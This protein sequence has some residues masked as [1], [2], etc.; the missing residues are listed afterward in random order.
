MTPTRC[1]S[2]GCGRFV[3]AGADRC[4][5]HPPPPA[6]EPD[7]VLRPEI[8]ALRLVLDRLVREMDD[9]E[10]LARHIPRVT[11]V[12]IQAA[13]TQ[14]QIGHRGQ[15]DILAILGPALD[16]L[17][18]ASARAGAPAKPPAQNAPGGEDA[19]T[20]GVAD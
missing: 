4:A 1:R 14:H 16:D 19:P 2:A 5:S 8:E 9:L 11:S 20:G 3:T 10:R 12:S 7:P 15:G 6:S 18:A 13:R 17:A